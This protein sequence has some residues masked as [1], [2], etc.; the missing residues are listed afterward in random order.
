MA[1]KSNRLVPARAIHPGE[2]LREELLERGIKQKDFAR[3]IGVQPTHLNEFIK[4]KRNLNEGLAIKLEKA[5]GISY[6]NW[7]SLHAGY[8]YD[9]KAIEEKKNEELK[10]LDFENACSDMFNLKAL[11]K[12]LDM[13]LMPCVDRVAQLKGMLSFDLLSAEHLRLQVAGLYKHSEKVQID[14]KN[15]SLI[16]I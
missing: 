3:T 7:M 11:Y 10:A 1:T 15:L 12:R 5:L 2:V 8:L 14:E 13:S 9:C 6:T 16:H 4:G